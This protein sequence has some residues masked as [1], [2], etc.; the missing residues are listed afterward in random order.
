M[1]PERYFIVYKPFRM[2]SQFV[3]PYEQ[4]KL[5]ALDFVFPE[6]TNA[7]GRLDDESEGLLI[8]TTDKTLTHRL[9]HPDKQHVR[10]YIVQVEKVVSEETLEK[11]RSGMEILVKGRGKYMTRPCKVEII[12]KPE[13]LPQRDESLTERVPCSWLKF[14]LMEGKNRQIRKMCKGVRHKCRRLIRTQIEDLEL[15]NMQP[16]EV[17][18]IPRTELFRLL[19]I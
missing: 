1:I 3:S 8:L 11:L 18:E 5:D 6:G 7:V 14:V 17:K 16:G 15:G 13:N 2:V 9:L 4:R 10:S 12:K 19:K